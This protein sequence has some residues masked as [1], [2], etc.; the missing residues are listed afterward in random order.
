MKSL[1][2]SGFCLSLIN[3]QHS[4]HTHRAFQA[5]IHLLTDLRALSLLRHRP[6][7]GSTGA[8]IVDRITNEDCLTRADL[9]DVFAVFDRDGD[10]FITGK[11][12]RS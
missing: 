6:A 2:W 1:T 5:L 10:G 8:E 7:M 4:T 12:V 3:N 9:R 11:C